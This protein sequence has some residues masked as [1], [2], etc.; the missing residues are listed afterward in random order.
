MS[1]LTRTVTISSD[2]KDSPS[3]T[4]SNF[5]ATLASMQDLTNVTKVIVSQIMVRNV[6]YN[7]RTGIND[8]LNLYRDGVLDNTLVVPEGFWE[9]ND[10]IA[11]IIA[12]F[13]TAM[14]GGVGYE[15]NIEIQPNGK[16][17]MYLYNGSYGML[18]IGNAST[19]AGLLG[20]GYPQL[21]VDHI[22]ASYWPDLEG[23]GSL[24]IMS[25]KVGSGNLLES[26]SNQQGKVRS[27]LAIVPIVA[28][29]QAL[30][31]WRSL[32]SEIDSI[33]YERPRNLSSIDIRIEN[34]VGT[35]VD[36][37]NTEI[38]VQLKIFYSAKR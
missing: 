2:D 27:C 1:I 32:D 10:L 5:T 35:I 18:G 33:Y 8:T 11:Y 31:V 13:P 38:K 28:E 24:Y 37:G 4:N 34:D 29:F 23:L 36:I 14:F 15:L 22:Y 16:W 25:D 30:N 21:P 19:L 9:A 6:F 12:G 7:V 20:F 17:H 3:M 26:T